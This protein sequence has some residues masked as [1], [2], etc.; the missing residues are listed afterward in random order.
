MRPYAA[1]RTHAARAP[2]QPW[3]LR[4]ARIQH[5]C[6][7]GQAGVDALL[8]VRGRSPYL[9]R[10]P[11]ADMRTLSPS[12]F[13]A[14]CLKARR[15]ATHCTTGR[16]T[17]DLS[18]TPGRKPYHPHAPPFFLLLHL[19]RFVNTKFWRRAG[20]VD[21]LTRVDAHAYPDHTRFVG[22]LPFG[23]CAAF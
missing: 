15:R 2:W 20:L 21:Y 17:M 6:C 10:T 9:L 11:Q 22:P 13:D 14:A 1:R 4:T 7:L 16:E 8:A 19:V 12:R 23:T 5:A 3:T 18:Y